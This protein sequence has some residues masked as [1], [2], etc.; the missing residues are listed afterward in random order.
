MALPIE[1]STVIMTGTLVDDQGTPL[2]GTV[3]VSPS[4][5]QLISASTHRII[6]VLPRTIQLDSNGSLSVPL[7]S[8]NEADVLPHGLVWSITIPGQPGKFIR[9]TVPDDAET[10][11]IS[12]TIVEFQSTATDEPQYLVGYRG[13]KGDPGPKGDTGPSGYDDSLINAR[14]T[15]LENYT[16]VH[17]VVWNGTEY[18][19]RPPGVAAGYVEYVGPSQPTDWLTGDTWV[20]QA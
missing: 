15:I 2:T 20:E 19:G 12:E 17:R 5:D 4:M 13:P 6:E 18:P 10:A 14:V 9:F 3:T 8:S 11:D 1:I 16:V 7:I